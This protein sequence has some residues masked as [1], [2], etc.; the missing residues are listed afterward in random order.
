MP[1]IVNPLVDVP[2]ERAIEY[3]FAVMRLAVGNVVYCPTC[4]VDLKESTDSRRSLGGFPIGVCLRPDKQA[5]IAMSI[6]LVVDVQD[7]AAL[8][9]KNL[10]T[11]V[12][13]DYQW[14][15]V[16]YYSHY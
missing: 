3:R 16:D 4:A 13:A 15:F 6:L 9:Q 5:I 2:D 1:R 11:P 10:A 8:G 12:E 14:V 7:F